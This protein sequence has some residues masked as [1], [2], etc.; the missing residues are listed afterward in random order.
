MKQ[1]LQGLG[2][3]LYIASEIAR[4]HGGTLYV[5]SSADETRFTFRMPPWAPTRPVGKPQ[6]VSY[7]DKL[8]RWNIF[9]LWLLLSRSP[10]AE[11]LRCKS[12]QPKM[13]KSLSALLIFSLLGASV[14]ALLGFAPTW[15]LARRW[16]R[17]TGLRSEGRP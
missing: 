11:G 3:G 7:R 2:L 9:S 4:A 12:Q 15:K 10:R 13:V 8:Y 17:Q 1:S 16:P 6:T 14:I 5:N